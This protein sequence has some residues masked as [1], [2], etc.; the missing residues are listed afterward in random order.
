MKLTS[1]SPSAGISSVFS[2]FLTPSTSNS[3]MRV[4][5]GL[6]D[7]PDP[8]ADLDRLA[9]GRHAR[10]RLGRIDG[11]VVDLLGV[12]RKMNVAIFEPL[13]ALTFATWSSPSAGRSGSQAERAR[14]VRT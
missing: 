11:D 1:C 10:G 2:P 5:G 8:A 9:L 6:A 14:S 4:A 12:S 3:T 7:G 13:P